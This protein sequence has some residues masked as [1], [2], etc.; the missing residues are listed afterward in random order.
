MPIKIPQLPSIPAGTITGQTSIPVAKT[1]SDPKTYKMSLDQTLTWLL[2]NGVGAGFS[3]YSGFSGSAGTNGFSG[4]SGATGATGPSGTN[5]VDGA[6]RGLIIVADPTRV[7]YFR[8]DNTTSYG[9]S[10]V[11]ITA[12]TQN[13]SP[14]VG[15]PVVFTITRYN[16][17]GSL[18]STN[19]YNGSGANY[20][21][22]NYTVTQ[23]GSAQTALVSAAYTSGTDLY[24]DTEQLI[25]LTDGLSGIP[26]ENSLV[27]VLTN[28]SVAL[29]S[30]PSGYVSNY[31]LATG[32][33]LVYSGTNLIPPGSLTFN[34]TQNG[35]TGSLNS[36]TG[37]YQITSIPDVSESGSLDMTATYGSKTVSATFT[38]TKSK[39]GT[40]GTAKSLTLNLN[41]NLFRF[42]NG[43]PT[44]SSDSITA[45]A[46]LDNITPLAST[47]T[48]NWTATLYNTSYSP[49]AFTLTSVPG[50]SAVKILPITAF[51]NNPGAIEC[52]INATIDDIT[53]V[54]YGDSQSV[55]RIDDGTNG[56]NGTSG[57]SGTNAIF[58]SLTNDNAS[59]N[60]ASD[61]TVNVSLSALSGD[62]IVYSGG[63]DVTLS[64]VGF[65]LYDTING[66]GSTLTFVTG[67]YGSKT[68]RYKV[69][70]IGATLNVSFILSAAY[71]GTTIYKTFNV[72]KVVA[73]PQG[74]TG[75]GPVY[76]GTYS[77]SSTYYFIP[78]VRTDIVLYSGS[79]Y[80]TKNAAKSGSAGWGVPSSTPADWESFGA[81]F[82]SVATN[83]LLTQDALVG[84]FLNMGGDTG[85]AN[86]TTAIRSYSVTPTV[87]AS[88]SGSQTIMTG[89]GFY[90]G[91]PT[92]KAINSGNDA[93]FFVG[94]G[95]GNSSNY[96]FWDGDK[97]K[98]Q[99]LLE[100][101]ALSG[102][103]I[104]SGKDSF[105]STNPGFRLGLENDG[106]AKFL[107]GDS[108]KS[109]SW[110]GS[111]LTTTGA[112]QNL[113]N[114]GNLYLNKL[115]PNSTTA[116]F[117]LG[118]SAGN[119]YFTVGSNDSYL[120][121]DDSTNRVI[122]KGTETVDGIYVSSSIGMRYI[123][124]TGVYTINGGSENGS[125]NGAQI[126][127]AGSSFPVG[128]NG[129]TV[130]G[131][132]VLQAG[133]P[134]GGIP[135]SA[136]NIYFRTGPVGVGALSATPK[137]RSIIRYDGEFAISPNE[138]DPATLTLSG[139]YVGSNSFGDRIVDTTAPVTTTGYSNGD[140]WL[141]V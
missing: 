90:M 32:Q 33:F 94:N 55:L 122:I 113:A 43:S 13:L 44:V 62:F 95:F 22:I 129:Q 41:K 117:W 17:A 130:A 120:K 21:T 27:G 127:L 91:F 18:I 40:A 70:N 89:N 56:T 42:N 131:A 20:N 128:G 81:S 65:G 82:E 51:S 11:T 23:F 60:A 47:T 98:I 140:I 8:S 88:W 100:I 109:L 104:Y 77:G 25:R 31:S 118:L 68:N 85:G 24:A 69:T 107:I 16:S 79:Y 1:S 63:T 38:V 5:G 50:N 86:Q 45:T 87:S 105:T 110:N 137:L 106:T 83:L 115:N 49:S 126:D 28:Y 54:T 134:T 102:M 48:I 37:I 84:R 7:F 139:N 64:A 119:A 116:G 2:A 92:A 53:S 73:G 108:S 58:G 80:K 10:A 124:D 19:T 74:D 114:N 66:G 121:Y 141:V 103:A 99:G 123:N 59:I 29:P 30:T 14:T 111:T 76:Q 4:Y 97:L 39:Q 125:D 101:A 3:G 112:S 36:S 93:V 135:T 138:G 46:F 15:N 67:A 6:T 96:M 72:A 133:S 61:G 52:V 12:I 26:G 9:A 71:N 34:Y 132:L 75:A 35:I 57:T 78:G 136:A